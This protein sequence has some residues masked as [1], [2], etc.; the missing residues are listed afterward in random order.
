MITNSLT[1]EFLGRGAHH[2][3]VPDAIV[4]RQTDG[5]IMRYV[6]EVLV[7]DTAPVFKPGQIVRVLEN[8]NV[9]V[10]RQGVVV[11]IEYAGAVNVEFGSPFGDHHP[12]KWLFLNPQTSLE[13][14]YEVE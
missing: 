12:S 6:P 7:V 2:D 10:G 14:I 4:L 8:Y 1:Y 9:C 3:I 13:I 5:K 11:H